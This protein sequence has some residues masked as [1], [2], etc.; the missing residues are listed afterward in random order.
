MSNETF[1]LEALIAQELARQQAEELLT[2]LSKGEGQLPHL[3]PKLDAPTAQKRYVN[4]A[5]ETLI[6]QPSLRNFLSK[7]DLKLFLSYLKTGSPAAGASPPPE[8]LPEFSK[9]CPAN[10]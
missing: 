8:R 10:R 4:F 2:H 3:I 9:R 1:D 5:V 6:S 7:E